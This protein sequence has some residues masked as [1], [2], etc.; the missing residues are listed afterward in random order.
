[1]ATK[2]SNDD[3]P[4][5]GDYVARIKETV[6]SEY[7]AWIGTDS[8]ER[9]AVV[10]GSGAGA[11]PNL[12]LRKGGGGPT[13]YI[14]TNGVNAELYV[15]MI[16]ATGQGNSLNLHV[17]GDTYERVKIIGHPTESSLG[18]GGGTA[19]PDVRLYRGG[20][21]VGVFDTNG[22]PSNLY[23]AFIGP[24]GGGNSLILRLTGD[25]NERMALISHAWESS[26]QWGGGA[27][28]PDT[29]V[30]RSNAKELTF[31]DNASGAITVKGLG[32]L[33]GSAKPNAGAG[34][35]GTPGMIYM[36]NDGTAGSLWVMYGTGPTQWIEVAGVATTIVSGQT[37]IGAT[38]ATIVAA[39]T[40]RV[41]VTLVNREAR[42]VWVGAAG[43]TAGNGLQI[44]PGA[45]LTLHTSALVAGIAGATGAATE[46]VHYVEEY[47]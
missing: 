43:V 2:V 20:A 32:H 46:M 17:E 35:A 14:D 1:M 6:D 11:P 10:F 33:Q 21:G 5:A 19:A 30:Y 26:I 22:S 25:T 31:D 7:R 44:D 23:M 4:T 3:A 27:T 28:A 8:S 15:A 41:R 47:S 13:L 38:S 45:S 29:R 34:V 12:G 18:L 37:T 24:S 42:A 9:G 40:G 36:Q 39:R 16:G